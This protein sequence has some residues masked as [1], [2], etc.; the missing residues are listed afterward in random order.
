MGGCGWACAVTTR[1]D[2]NCLAYGVVGEVVCGF[3]G[4]G[5]EVFE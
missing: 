2:A 1:V 5:V 4:V 3:M